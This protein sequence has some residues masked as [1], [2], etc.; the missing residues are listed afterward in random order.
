MAVGFS[1]VMSSL[2]PSR[3]SWLFRGFFLFFQL[4]TYFFSPRDAV[5][6]PSLAVFLCSATPQWKERLRAWWPLAVSLFFFPISLVHMKSFLEW[7][8]R[9]SLW[10]FMEEGTY[11]KLFTFPSIHLAFAVIL[12][13]R[14]FLR[15]HGGISGTAAVYSTQ[16]LRASPPPWL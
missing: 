15:L 6:P 1:S 13:A 8:G 14:D 12:W 7:R 4:G 11:P 16:L 10:D 9:P 2:S 3:F 5:G